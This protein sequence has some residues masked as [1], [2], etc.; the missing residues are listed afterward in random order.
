M[1]RKDQKKLFLCACL[2][3]DP[4]IVF[5]KKTKKLT[6]KHWSYINAIKYWR[7]KY[8]EIIGKAKGLG[9][10]K[11]QTVIACNKAIEFFKNILHE[12]VTVEYYINFVLG[13]T[14]D[15][16]NETPKKEEKKILSKLEE[17]LFKLYVLFDPDLK[18]ENEMEK[19]SNHIKKLWEY[20]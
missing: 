19:A 11:K 1:A 16:Y 15:L 12:K 13:I 10:L 20:I 2:Y 7:K 6:I 14:S 5:L 3:D 4:F 18:K 8:V 9:D 17:N